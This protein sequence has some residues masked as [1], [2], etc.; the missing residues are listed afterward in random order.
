MVQMPVSTRRTSLSLL[1]IG[2]G[3]LVLQA[4]V[5]V[6][7]DYGYFIDEFYYLACARRLAWGYVDHPPLAPLVLAMTR[8]VLGESPLAIRVPAFLAGAVIV[9]SAGR[10][11]FEL[12]GGCWAALTTA[13]TVAVA[14]GVLAVTGFFSVNAFEALAWVLFTWTLVRLLRTGDQ[15]LWMALGLLAGLGFESKHTMLTLVAAASAGLVTTRARALLWNRWAAWGAALALALA[16]PNVI[17]QVVNGFPSLEFYRN[18]ATLKNLP[19]SPAV[20]VV[21]QLQLMGLLTA[22]VWLV[23]LGWVLLTRDGGSW[24]GLGVAFILLFL[25]LIGSRQSRPD[26]LLGLYPMLVAAGAVAIE[27]RVHR[28]GGRAA[29]TTLVLA[30]CLP[31]L[32][33]V[34]PVLPPAT[35]SRYVAWLGV[36]TSTERGKTSPIPQLLA[37]RTEW[38]PF[39]AQVAAVYRSL[40]PDD[41]RQALIYAPSYGQ[42]GAIDLL[43]RADGLPRTIAGQNSYWHWSEREGVDSEVLIAI[44]ANPDD[45]RAL[46]RD[47]EQVGVTTCTYCMS[48]RRGMPIDVAR[49]SIAPV[50]SIWARARHYE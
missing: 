33:V 44:G 23:G 20:V 25:L 1:L 48:W 17:W 47:V 26:R 6:C 7:G 42:A 24:R 30:G 16:T 49:R 34:I 3:F 19:A 15:R 45:L 14:P 37:D 13:A 4:V 27:R 21:G 29:V 35:L 43:G 2:G 36:E 8:L 22:P 31:G 5:T 38:E 18:A 28:S 9:W 50:S 39:V 41:R 40:S 11:V 46:F 32:P 12:G 10:M